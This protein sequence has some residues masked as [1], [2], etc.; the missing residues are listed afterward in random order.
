M[1][2]SS[3]PHA[4]AAENEDTRTHP[5]EDAV[6][7]D[8]IHGALGGN[9]WKK[10][11]FV[12][13]E[14]R[15]VTPAGIGDV[16][17][18]KL[19][20]MR[21][22]GGYMLLA[23]KEE[24]GGSANTST[25]SHQEPTE[26]EKFEAAL[27]EIVDL[28]LKDAPEA[29]TQ[30]EGEKGDIFDPETAAKLRRD[31]LKLQIRGYYNAH[32]QVHENEDPGFIAVDCHGNFDVDH[33]NPG[34]ELKQQSQ[35]ITSGYHSVKN[36][37]NTAAL[38]RKRSRLTNALIPGAE[39]HGQLQIE[40]GDEGY[41]SSSS[42][43]SQ[44]HCH[45]SPYYPS[46]DSTCWLK[47][48]HDTDV[49]QEMPSQASAALPQIL[50]IYKPLEHGHTRI[51]VLHPGSGAEP[52]VCQLE[53]M[54]IPTATQKNPK[55]SETPER[56]FEALS[57]AW[58]SSTRTHVITCNGAPFPITTNL[59][60]AL[61]HLRYPDRMRKLWVDAICI[62]QNDV[63]ERSEQVRH[64]LKIYQEALH[65]IVW[66]GL[67]E[68]DGDLALRGMNYLYKR[69]NRKAIM[70]RDHD[71]SC[72][73]HLR[74]LISVLEA[75]FRRPWFFRSWIRQEVAA[76]NSIIV[77]CGPYQTSWAAM[78]RAANCMWRLREKILCTEQR[79]L[80][81]G[82]T[83]LFKRAGNGDEELALRFLK[84][85]WMLGESLL[86]QAGDIRSV[87][88]YHTGSL[89][90]LL[91]VSRAFDATDPRDK[92]YSTLGMAEVPTESK[93][94]SQLEPGKD[95]LCID[96]SASVSE[97]YQHAAKFIINRDR[98]L[99]ILC[100]LST[101][102]DGN[103][104]DLPTW[105]PDWRVPLSSIPLR[106]DMEYFKHKW[107]A[108]GFT[109]ASRQDQGDGDRLVV[110]GF[111]VDKVTKLLPL[112]PVSI[113]H[114]PERPTADM[115]VFDSTL[116]LRR[117]AMTEKGQGAV[118][119]QTVESDTIW[120]LLGCKMPMVLRGVRASQDEKAY[121]V[122]GPCWIPGIMHGQALRSFRENHTAEATTIALY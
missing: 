55:S 39:S 44:D 76:A 51:L 48:V 54:R 52:L 78:K 49:K 101:H 119:S 5:S 120:V 30:P 109:K 110:Q 9:V 63:M 56:N 95:R 71:Q 75:F 32:Q 115:V 85:H 35:W 100:I 19:Y 83:K 12:D 121:N 60:Y 108:A 118:P 59:F 88:Y 4:Q 2:T 46:C 98:N 45:V 34:P 27:D 90:E 14:P 53:D 36:P 58:G 86:D 23:P 26:A 18:D 87:W 10:A 103:S 80:G 25:R 73:Q 41:D 91:M 77:K 47:L 79:S 64:M 6:D 89:L 7:S 92:V 13:G 68:K 15:W 104:G 61:A 105:T 107:G 72:L 81:D 33:G 50:D 106:A 38:R 8:T 3:P 43:V 66:L 116:H 114:P 67:P 57:Y 96:Y 65:V 21:Q 40:H 97:V 122:I 16:I 1:R 22:V 102:R 69:E 82:E 24:A 113:P 11:V 37:D 20:H 62:N 111:P 117:F 74:R 29:P 31:H 99:D 28:A 84:R 112:S 70:R 93:N 94:Q 17:P 42:E